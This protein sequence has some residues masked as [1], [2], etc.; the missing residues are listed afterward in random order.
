MSMQDSLMNRFRG[1]FWGLGLGELALTRSDSLRPDSV[2]NSLWS[3]QTLAATQ[4]WLRLG[5]GLLKREPLQHS[6]LLP[7]LVP[8]ALLY[9]D[10]PQQMQQALRDAYAASQP[11]ISR[12][13]DAQPSSAQPSSAIDSAVIGQSFSLIL[14]ERFVAVELIPQVIRDLDLALHLPLVQKLLQIQSGLT[15]SADLAAIAHLLEAAGT[16][17]A[18]TPTNFALV[19]AFYCFLSS[20]DEFQLSLRRLQRL[21]A[22]AEFNSLA[23]DPVLAGGILGGVSGLYNGLVGLPMGWMNSQFRQVVPI[24][25]DPVDLDMTRLALDRWDLWEVTL[26]QS[27]DQLLMRWAGASFGT[28]SGEWLQQPHASLIAAPRVIRLPLANPRSRR[29]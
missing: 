25:P 7:D 11:I 29:D 23:I 3:M 15:Q 19:L 9:H 21:I 2:N 20:P 8:I 5:T 27:A 6:Q 14:R 10:Q 22:V 13:D 1:A 24:D 4:R 18:V 16:D 17:A 12:P 28:S 26:M